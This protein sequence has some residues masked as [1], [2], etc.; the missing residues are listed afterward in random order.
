MLSERRPK[1]HFPTTRSPNLTPKHTARHQ[2]PLPATR[3][4]TPSRI[5]ERVASSPLRQ[6]LQNAIYHTAKDHSTERHCQSRS[7][8]VGKSQWRDG[9][10]VRRT[11]VE[12]DEPPEFSRRVSAETVK[13]LKK[14]FD[15][16]S[17]I[18]ISSFIDSLL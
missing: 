15:L 5:E 4:L 13:F 9:S 18:P 10:R 3:N 16:E 1:E 12:D 8:V 2:P 17:P 6:P 11:L 14:Y 7:R